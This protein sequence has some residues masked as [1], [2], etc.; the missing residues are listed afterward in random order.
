MTDTPTAPFV[1]TPGTV[2][3]WNNKL[4]QEVDVSD[5][6]IIYVGGDDAGEIRIEAEGAQALA[7]LILAAPDLLAALVGLL[8]DAEA[9]AK[10]MG[11]T[12]TPI[13]QARAALAKAGS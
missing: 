13:L 3:A 12:S 10:V 6:A 8:P 1:L 5:E 4:G 7:R 11:Y 9:A 2:R